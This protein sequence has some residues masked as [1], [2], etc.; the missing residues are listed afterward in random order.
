MEWII[1]LLV[2]I[3]LGI[4]ELFTLS[5]VLLMLGGGAVAA[6]IAAALGAPVEIQALVFTV[7]SILALVVVRPVARRMREN[8]TD[9]AAGIGLQALEGGSA[10]VLERTDNHNGLI[11][12]DGE[13]WTARSFDG[14]QVLE[15]GEEVKI[16]EIRGA[17]AMVWRQP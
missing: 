9:P 8:R 13:T 12:I 17:T 6:A 10:L 14:D 3:G 16:V 2:A 7:V 5:F 15:P 11:K 1:W 4:A